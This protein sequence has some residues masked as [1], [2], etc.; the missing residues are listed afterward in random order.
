MEKDNSNISYEF[1]GKKFVVLGA[2]SGMGRQTADEICCCGGN[3][4]AIARNEDRLATL[5]EQFPDNIVIKSVDVR[6]KTSL[7]SC[8]SDYVNACGRIDG[9]VYTAGISKTT[10]LRSFSEEDARTTMD[11]NYWGWIN[12]MSILS[13]R[14]YSVDGS[15]HVVISSVA[16]HIGE[17]GNFAYDASKAA[18]ITCV[19]AFAKEIAK[20]KCRVNSISPGF[21]MSALSEGY[22]DTRGYS[23]KVVEKHLLGFGT[24][25]DVSGLILYLLSDRARWITGSDF[26][27]DGGYLVSD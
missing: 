23:D 2:S 18:I 27:I 26:I 25:E 14:K 20:R 24:V 13:K 19:K 11:T 12:S 22:F 10:A 4:L 7:E 3:V 21:V 1:S 16:A 17:A 15:A 9:S 8:I 6:D 5:K